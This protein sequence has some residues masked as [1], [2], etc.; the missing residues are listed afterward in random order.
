MRANHDY[1]KKQE[2]RRDKKKSVFIL[3]IEKFKGLFNNKIFLFMIV[4]S[5]VPYKKYS[6]DF[7][8]LKHIDINGLE[9]EYNSLPDYITY[10]K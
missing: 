10:R 6:L 8:K 3:F 5:I 9:K 2:N 1:L 7:E 4:D